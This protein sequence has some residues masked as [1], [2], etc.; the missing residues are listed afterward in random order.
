MA[1]D[2]DTLYEHFGGF[3]PI[4]NDGFTAM[5][6]VCRKLCDGDLDLVLILSAIGTRTLMNRRTAGLSY[7]EFREGHR[8]AGVSRHINLQSIAEG[9][10]I[11]RETV[12]RKINSLIERG[13][14]RRNED[15]TLEV[16]GQ[17]VADLAPATQAT[18]DYLLDVGN[19]VLDIVAATEKQSADHPGTKKHG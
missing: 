6:V 13:R 18:F 5:L 15:N 12:R 19:A 1:L 14:V 16:T 11:P 2:C 17:A 10:G 8:P 3:W 4:H 7:S 9:T